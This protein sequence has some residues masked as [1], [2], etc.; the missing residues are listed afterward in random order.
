MMSYRCPNCRAESRHTIPVPVFD[1]AVQAVYWASCKKCRVAWPL[2]IDWFYGDVDEGTSVRPQEFRLARKAD[3]AVL[4]EP[5]TRLY[6][7][8]DLNYPLDVYGGS[9]IRTMDAINAGRH[10]RYEYTMCPH[11]GD[12]P[13]H[14]VPVPESDLSEVEVNWGFCDR[15]WVGWPSWAAYACDD[16]LTFRGQVA[17]LK[18]RVGKV[19]APHGLRRTVE[20]LMAGVEP[21]PSGDSY[22]DLKDDL[23][24]G[25]DNP[26]GHVLRVVRRVNGRRPRRSGPSR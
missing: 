17:L 20:N 13:G 18:Q 2:L 16:E 10:A 22:A 24:S 11:C 19:V 12:V 3:R 8:A 4:P 26:L 14:Y 15:C 21:C 25:P 6:R 1:G 5:L 7:Y 23:E 9:V